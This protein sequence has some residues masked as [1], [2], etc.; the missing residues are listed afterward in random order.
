M[1][2]VLGLLGIA[3]SV[4]LLKYRE[5]VGNIFGEAEWM[6]KVGGIY[7]IVIIAAGIVFLGSIAMLTGTEYILLKPLLLLFPG[8]TRQPADADPFL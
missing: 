3:L 1:K 7:G 5:Q 6:R 8:F 4:Y 2:Y